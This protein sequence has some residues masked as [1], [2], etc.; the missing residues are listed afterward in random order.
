LTQKTAKTLKEFC[1]NTDSLKLLR[2]YKNPFAT[3]WTNR[4]GVITIEFK[5]QPGNHQ[6]MDFATDAIHVLNLLRNVSKTKEKPI[7]LP[8]LLETH[9]FGDLP[10]Y[11]AA[12]MQ[13]YIESFTDQGVIVSSGR[14]LQ[15]LNIHIATPLDKIRKTHDYSIEERKYL[16]IE[17]EL[18][19]CFVYNLRSAPIQ[20]GEIISINI[21]NG[22]EFYTQTP[23]AKISRGVSNI[24]A[25]TYPKIP[26]SIIS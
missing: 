9:G 14:K 16:V 19:N 7:D 21:R 15:K 22:F 26:K 6:T 20:N 10:F 17:K 25:A 18:D 5:H 3:E 2:E 8:S 4:T 11:Q 13:M 23:S 24:I 1:D 12:H